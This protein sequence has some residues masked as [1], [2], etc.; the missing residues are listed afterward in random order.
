MDDA[1]AT[2]RHGCEGV[3]SPAVWVRGQCCSSRTAIL[4]K[5]LAPDDATLTPPHEISISLSRYLSPAAA[6]LLLPGPRARRPGL[7]PAVRQHRER[8]GSAFPTAPRLGDLRRP[9]VRRRS[10]RPGAVGPAH[11]RRSDRNLLSTAAAP[12]IRLQERFGVARAG[13][14]GGA[15]PGVADPSDLTDDDLD[16]I[17]GAVLATT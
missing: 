12:P 2:R 3:I 15:N 13:G 6:P 9:V 11:R 7:R 1:R 4:R 10:P 17:C 16:R 5:F 14:F 8:R